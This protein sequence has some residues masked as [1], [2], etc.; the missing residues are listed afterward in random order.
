VD[1]QG[2]YCPPCQRAQARDGDWTSRLEDA[3]D[4][5]ADGMAFLGPGVHKC[6]RCG[7]VIGSLDVLADHDCTP[8]DADVRMVRVEDGAALAL[9]AVIASVLLL[10]NHVRASVF[11]APSDLEEAEDWCDYCNREFE[12]GP[13]WRVEGDLVTGYFCTRECAEEW[14]GDGEPI[15]P[16]GQRP[17]S[18]TSRFTGGRD[19]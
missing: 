8:D 15:R 1:C 7:R 19:A 16:V 9:G 17:S 6:D 10:A 2:R 13:H 11:A 18:V 12:H 5:E 4:L 3:G 14:R